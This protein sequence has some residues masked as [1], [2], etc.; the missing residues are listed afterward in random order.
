MSYGNPRAG[1]HLRYSAHRFGDQARC[2]AGD[3]AATECWHC[4]ND[5]G[6]EVQAYTTDRP[7]TD[8][9]DVVERIHHE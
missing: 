1:G 9:A 8:I 3:E 2:R 6:R 5:A 7:S 4:W